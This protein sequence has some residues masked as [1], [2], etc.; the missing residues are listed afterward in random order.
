[1]AAS[2]F[3]SNETTPFFGFLGAAAALVFSCKKH[4]LDLP[5]SSLYPA[6]SIHPFLTPLT[7]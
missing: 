7:L 4:P 2:T 5:L 6:G 1:M 3:S